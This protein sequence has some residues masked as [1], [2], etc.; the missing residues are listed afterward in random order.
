M[1]D[2]PIDQFWPYNA[3]AGIEPFRRNRTDPVVIV[4]RFTG[5][6]PTPQQTNRPCVIRLRM[7]TK[8]LWIDYYRNRN[9][10]KDGAVTEDVAYS[11]WYCICS[12]L[13]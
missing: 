5:H 9:T 11:D 4:Y 12:Y 8:I 7:L 3:L 1:A 13:T 2:H 10:A 6:S